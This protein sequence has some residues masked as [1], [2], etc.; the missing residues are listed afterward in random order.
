MPD[1]AETAGKGKLKNLDFAR[2]YGKDGVIDIACGTG[3]VLMYLAE[4]D[5]ISDGTDLSEAMCRVADEKARQKGFRLNILVLYE[6]VDDIDKDVAYPNG[7]AFYVY[8]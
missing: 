3:A 1:K 5:I 6:F 7:T 4:H 8:K 2:E